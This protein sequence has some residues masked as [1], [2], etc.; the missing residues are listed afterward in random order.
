MIKHKGF[1]LIE[2]IVVI[3]ILGVLAVTAV[4]KFSDL[5][6]EAKIATLKGM[7]GAMR[8]GATIIHSQAMIESK[9]K[10]PATIE[11][12]G[13]SISLHSG[14]PIG[15]FMQGFR[16]IVNLDA[17]NFSKAS[18]ICNVEWCGRGNQ[19]SIPSGTKTTSTG[20]IGKV[21]PKGYSWNDECGVYYVN[22]KNGT[23]PEIGLETD[24]C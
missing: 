3:V 21:F 9:V 22:H 4:S 17:V 10:G 6:R 5:S 2:L 13:A 18:A 14:Y 20:R 8:S 23:K 24:E 7:E 1:T 15:N 12:G 19:K 16:Y 11:L